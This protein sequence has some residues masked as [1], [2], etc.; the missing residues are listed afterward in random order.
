M[1]AR[2]I[3]DQGLSLAGVIVIQF[4]PQ[5][6]FV[7]RVDADKAHLGDGYWE[8]HKAVVTRPSREPETFDTYTVSTYLSR[9]R[10]GEAMGSEIAVSV[11]QLPSLIEIAEKAGLSASRYKMQ[12]ALLTSRPMLLMAM[13]ILAAT[14]SLRSFRSG[15]TQTMVVTGMVGGIGFFLLTEVSRQ[16]GVAGL[17]SATAAAWMPISVALLVSLTV[18]LHQEDG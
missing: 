17:V 12:Y 3:A 14:V 4:D 5:G 8:L 10:V 18:L 16:I 11:W 9:E 13:V 15:G 7:E 6:R 2:A 1:N